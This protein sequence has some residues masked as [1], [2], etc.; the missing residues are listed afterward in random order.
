MTMTYNEKLKDPRWIAFSENTKEDAN[1]TCQNCGRSRPQVTL[2]V[3]HHIYLKGYEPWEYPAEL[4]MCLCRDCHKARHAPE[5]NL[6]FELACAM[7]HLKTETLNSISLW[8]LGKAIQRE[9]FG[10]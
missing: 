1:Y 5:A 3:H 6:Y 8:D 7:H 9:E 10:Q 2:Q 4:L